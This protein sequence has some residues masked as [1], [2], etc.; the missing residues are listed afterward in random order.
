M[1]D[2]T[3]D[4]FAESK[5]PFTKIDIND[6]GTTFPIG[7]TGA[8]TTYVLPGPPI[9][10]DKLIIVQDVNVI[11]TTFEDS[12]I[13]VRVE[14]TNNNEVNT[15]IG[16]RYFWDTIIGGDDGP[17]MQ[18]ILPAGNV[19]TN[20]TEFVQPQFEAFQIADNDSN[21]NPPTFIV[22]GTAA[23]IDT[24]DTGIPPSLIQY[25]SWSRSSSTA[26]DYQIDPD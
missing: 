1:T 9:T 7:A 22:Y 20:E 8:R 17:T 10:P 4:P 5:P 18:T 26:F 23:G 24:I 11:G 16:I 19:L 12:Y 3:V 21:P 2:Y 14:V 25:V 15:R 13:Q 6:F